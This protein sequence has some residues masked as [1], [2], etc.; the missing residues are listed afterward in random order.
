MYITLSLDA[1]RFR[2]DMKRLKRGLKI[3]LG[4]GIIEPSEAKNLVHQMANHITEYI[5]QT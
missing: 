1:N 4:L 3:L 5:I 2:R